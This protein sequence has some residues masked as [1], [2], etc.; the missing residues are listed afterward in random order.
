MALV[1]AI[2]SVLVVGYLACL[3]W[4]AHTYQHTALL[5]LFSVIGGVAVRSLVS[6]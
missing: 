2:C 6:R 5:L 1:I 3:T 4:S